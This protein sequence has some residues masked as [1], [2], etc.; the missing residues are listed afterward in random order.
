MKILFDEN[1]PYGYEAFSTLGVAQASPGRAITRDLL[2]DVELLF[3]RSVTPVNAA[4]LEGTPVRFVATATSGSDHIDKDYLQAKQ[5]AFCDAIGSNAESV[6]EYVTAALLTLSELTA[7]PLPAR[8]IA[9]IGVGHVGRL[10]LAKARALGLRPI[11]TDPPRAR[12]EPDFP[13]TPIDDA[14]SAD[15]ITL[16][17][18]LTFQGQDATFHLLNE[19]RLNALKPG[20]WLIQTSRG[21]VVDSRSL[22]A[23]LANARD[24][25]S[26]LDVWENEPCPEPALIAR[27]TIAT[28]HIAG[29][30]WPSKINATKIIY[31]AACKFLNTTPS[32]SPPQLPTGMSSPTL[33]LDPLQPTPSQITTAVRS[34]YDILADDSRMR[35]LL[36]KPLSEHGPYFD[37]LRKNY[38]IRLE[39]HH[40]QV[41]G[42]SPPA[43]SVLSQLG[44][45]LLT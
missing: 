20:T 41:R 43:A 26:V 30:S 39:F 35:Q 15:I 23:R 40:T 2:R 24:L 29:Y 11:L 33:Y 45:T 18:P 12:T 1:I 14:L 25:F 22:L 44:F 3:V 34:V 36:F 27:A 8:S 5:I 9:I 42:A 13:H 17:T 19:R 16:H 10:V 38:P 6:A 32:W 7:T 37:F 21:E 28:P 31:D 4:L